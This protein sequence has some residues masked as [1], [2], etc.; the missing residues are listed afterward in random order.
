L[1]EVTLWDGLKVLVDADN[2]WA[3]IIG[4]L[5]RIL[6]EQLRLH[7]IHLLDITI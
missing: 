4:D 2:N 3:L 6:G 5:Q 7:P 1:E